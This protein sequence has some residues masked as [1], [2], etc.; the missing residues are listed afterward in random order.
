MNK[1]KAIGLVL[2]FILSVTGTTS[3][4][5]QKTVIVIHEDNEFKTGVEL[6][7]KEKYG[8]AQKSFIKVIESHRDLNSLVRIDAEFYKAICAIELFNKDGEWF[9]KQ[10]VKNHPESP[11]VKIAYFYLGKYNY[12]KKKYQDANT[13]FEKVDIYDLTTEELSEFY[14]KR[15]YSSFSLEKYPEAKKDFYEIKDVDNKYAA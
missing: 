4:F 2:T 11:K 14:F 12:S 7:Q 1:L 13:W 15:G 6:F 9:L 8:A 10:F 5:A 3:V